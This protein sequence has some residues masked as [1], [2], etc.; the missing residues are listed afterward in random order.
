MSNQLTWEIRALRFTDEFE[1]TVLSSR[2]IFKLPN[3]LVPSSG[4]TLS[5]IVVFGDIVNNGSNICCLT[6]VETIAMNEKSCTMFK[7]Y[8]ERF[9]HNF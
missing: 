1:N 9:I 7:I 6:F 2:G 4:T 5:S 8:G 3:G